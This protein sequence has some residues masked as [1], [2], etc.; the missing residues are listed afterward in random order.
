MEK[1]CFNFTV[2]AKP[3]DPKTSIYAITSISTP[4]K[5]TYIIPEELQ[6]LNLHKEILKCEIINKVKTSLRKRHEKRE[7]WITL[8]NELKKTYIDEG[9]IQFDGFLLE[10]AEEKNENATTEENLTKLLEYLKVNEKGDRQQQKNKLK[11]VEKFVSE[12]FS[13]KITNVHQWLNNFES[14]CTRLEIITDTDKIE[15]LK[16]LMEESSMDWYNS[17]IIKNSINSEWIIW[18]NSLCET[19]S[20]KGWSPV[21]YA[22]NYRYKQG[23][24][25]EYAMKKERLLLEINKSIDIQTLINLIATGLP[26]FITDKIDREKVNTTNELFNNIRGLEHLI[27][28]TNSK[29]KYDNNT[30]FKIN[31]KD[32]KSPCTI[33]K[34]ENKGIRFHPESACW[35]KNKQE[36]KRKNTREEINNNL[37]EAEFENIDPKN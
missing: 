37:M 24:I 5:Q 7:V 3:D 10:K 32:N 16:L 18:K 8:T 20:N 34:K 29:E 26:N 21:R 11:L 36:D 33:C 22:F 27:K 15:M 14:E 13:G 17:M 31:Y 25:L 4:T 12:K 23:S 1:L 6:P 19:F 9:N 2:K 30:T 28:K 35:F